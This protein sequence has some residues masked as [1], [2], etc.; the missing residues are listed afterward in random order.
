M[1]LGGQSGAPTGRALPMSAANV[2][3]DC[4]G[5]CVGRADPA[6]AKRCAPC[7][8]VAIRA[9]ARRYY[10]SRVGPRP[11]CL[12]CGCLVNTKGGARRC[13]DCQRAHRNAR[14][15]AT[16]PR[17]PGSTFFCQGCS[18]A[19]PG[20]RSKWCSDSCF[21][22]HQARTHA[23]TPNTRRPTPLTRAE[24]RQRKRRRAQAA[25]VALTVLESMG[26]TVDRLLETTS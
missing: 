2:C 10:R 4:G 18:S 23:T 5:P 19:L 6:T 1:G 3:C 9:K 17:A 21:D 14:K 11:P 8:S 7:A 20:G 12:D 13:S 22:A 26:F 24:I 25:Q 15:R 16:R